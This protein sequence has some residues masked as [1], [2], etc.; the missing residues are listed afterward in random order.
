MKKTTWIKAPDGTLWK[1]RKN[2]FSD[3]QYTKQKLAE[4]FPLDAIMTVL[5]SKGD[6]IC[7][8]EL[9]TIFSYEK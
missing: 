2:N 9:Q 1:L 8:D 3:E 4:K 5:D 7:S 6:I